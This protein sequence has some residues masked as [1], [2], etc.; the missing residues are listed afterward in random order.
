MTHHGAYNDQPRACSRT[1][2][3]DPS[4]GITAHGTTWIASIEIKVIDESRG[5][6]MMPS[7]HA[8]SHNTGLNRRTLLTA[9]AWSIPV[10]AV[11]ISAPSA[12]A[13]TTTDTPSKLAHWI[14][15]PNPV[16][17]AQ[18]GDWQDLVLTISNFE[19][20][21]T[22]GTIVLQ[23]VGVE[24][25]DIDFDPTL[26]QF[27]AASPAGPYTS[28]VD[29]TLWSVSVGGSV[30]TF[31]SSVALEPGFGIGLPNQTTIGF[32]IH[33]KAGAATGSGVLVSSVWDSVTV[34]D[35]ARSVA[36]PL[37]FS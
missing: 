34:A 4:S 17:L 32:R 11:S 5:N 23:I 27:T 16:L 8:E 14:S 13:S 29:N 3:N 15:G 1:L 28:D 19:A 20:P 37:S 18:D 35:P 6:N 21:V 12:A 24:N 10:I 26:S 25:I 22:I 7:E 9:T 33:A 31:V 36:L 30:A 2:I